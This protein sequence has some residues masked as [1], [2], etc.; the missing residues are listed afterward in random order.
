MSLG[1]LV[2]EAEEKSG[3][4]ITASLALEQNRE[5][6]A[7][8]GSILSRQSRGTNGLIKEGAKLVVAVDDILAELSQYFFSPKNKVHMHANSELFS[9]LERKVMTI[10]CHEPRHIDAIA[11]SAA[12]PTA[13]VL[14]VMLSLELKNAVGQQPGKMFYRV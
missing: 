12:L 5:V 14:S 9:D 1:T 4:L 10:L 3:A 11:A 2:V 6:F 8:P 7:V 13:T